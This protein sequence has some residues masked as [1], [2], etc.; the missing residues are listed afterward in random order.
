MGRKTIFDAFNAV[1]GST[2]TA[3]GIADKYLEKR[4]QQK[5]FD[6]L[7][8]TKNAT[9]QFMIDM[10][11][12]NDWQNYDKRNDEFMTSLYNESA[13][14]LD[15]AYA[16][17]LY[18]N[19]FK[20]LELQQKVVVRGIANDKMRLED[21]TKFLDGQMAIIDSDTYTDQI[22]I[23]EDGKEYKVSAI[24]QQKAD[25]DRRRNGRYENGIINAEEFSRFQREEYGALLLTVLKKIGKNAIDNKAGLD[26]LKEAFKKIDECDEHFLLDN[27]GIV[28]TD[29]LKEKVKQ[30]TEGYF[31]EQQQLR[32]E[33][34]NQKASQIWLKVQESLSAGKW[35][36]AIDLCK[37]GHGF[38]ESYDAQ[39]NNDGFAANQRS[40]WAVRFN[41]GDEIRVKGGGMGAWG[42][43]AKAMKDE[44]FANFLTYKMRHG[45]TSSDGTH[46]IPSYKQTMSYLHNNIAPEL[47]ESMGEVKAL[48]KVFNIQN[49]VWDKFVDEVIPEGAR[50]FVKSMPKQIDAVLK[51]HLGDN[52]KAL[53]LG[54][55]K[56]DALTQMHEFLKTLPVNDITAEK[57]KEQLSDMAVG[58]VA[59]F[60]KEDVL[61]DQKIS[62]QEV[63]I[64]K[65]VDFFSKSMK[66][67]TFEENTSNSSI[68]Q[69]KDNIRGFAIKEIQHKEKGLHTTDD[70]LKSYT[71]DVNDNGEAV[72]TSIATG[73]I[74][75]IF[76][77]TKREKDGEI[78]YR[79][80][81]P[82]TKQA[83]KISG[84]EKKE[85][86]EYQE[87]ET[88]K[89]QSRV[90]MNQKYIEGVQDGLSY[91]YQRTVK[92]VPFEK[93]GLFEDIHDQIRGKSMLNRET[94]N[95]ITSE[96]KRLESKVSEF[97]K[98]GKRRVPERIKK[99]FFNVYEKA[100]Q[101][102]D[103]YQALLI[104]AYET[105]KKETK[106]N[107][108]SLVK[109]LDNWKSLLDE[110]GMSVNK[111][112]RL[113]Y[114]AIQAD[115]GE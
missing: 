114:E 59:N 88:Y 58:I 72:F 64:V 4:A 15:S 78:V 40:T 50:A 70:V 91:D 97:K 44:D 42:A 8:N 111:F 65:D 115:K 76:K 33:E 19:K 21:R 79:R 105:T 68:E 77:L 22:K 20:E 47:I 29:S 98:T 1:V 73:A 113:R 66:N 100:E 96:Y 92:K 43:V 14:K 83:D 60:N 67:G 82:R 17:E 109:V 30:F 108:I 11:N 2:E 103:Y 35:Q 57:L 51:E 93:Q 75:H 61:Y 25:L 69:A 41:L 38:L 49:K 36:N 37:Q 5:V 101:Q 87:K 89:F 104:D 86:R 9:H 48:S 106:D 107:K 90:G 46:I 74:T 10:Q 24:Q 53:D 63:A 45:E 81:D 99:Q 39:N 6:E 112:N 23:G 80:V 18:T 85:L 12:S 34:G 13:K 52:I 7:L 27:G 28:S 32:Y 110:R 54:K 31:R 62:K 102:G 71:V 94:Q 3:L 95:K 56:G 16:K 55:M 84:T 26:G